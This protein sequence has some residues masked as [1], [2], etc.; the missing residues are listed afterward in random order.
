MTFRAEFLCA[1]FCLVCLCHAQDA[2]KKEKVATPACAQFNV[3]DTTGERGA[4]AKRLWSEVQTE[5]SNTIA[6]VFVQVAQFNWL[7]PYTTPA[8]GEAAGSGFVIDDKGYLITNAHVISEAKAIGIQLPALGKERLDATL[9][10]VSFDRDIAL[11]RITQEGIDKIKAA[12]GCVPHIKLGNSDQVLRGD[13][14]MTLGYPLGQ[15]TLKSTVGV[16]SG[17]ETMEY[18]QYI[19]IDAP[20][21]PGNSGGPSVN[22][23]GEVVGV[24]TAGIPGAQNVGYIIPINELKIVLD[25]LYKL[26][27]VHNKELKKPFLGFGYGASSPAMAALFGNPVGGIYIVEVFKGGLLDK[28][29]VQRGDVLT[30][31]NGYAVDSYGQLNVPWCEDKISIDNYSYY[32]RYGQEVKLVLYRKGEKKNITIIFEHSI[33]PAIRVM[34]PDF[35]QIE[36]EVI[37]GMVI[38]QLTR[39]HLPLLLN[40]SPLL[41]RFSEPKKQLKPMLV[42]THII[43]DSVAQRSRVLAPAA[44]VKEVNGVKVRT[45]EQLREAVLKSAQ[46]GFLTVRVSEGFFAAFPISQIIADEPRLSYIYRYEISETIKKLAQMSS[47]QQI[48]RNPSIR[49]LTDS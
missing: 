21:N 32:L 47:T 6:Q 36:Y 13:E 14:I 26:E 7:E 24:N 8:Q 3:G 11:L 44:L 46:T 37:G 20:I 19:Q 16:V 27:S 5:V 18:R 4:R 48:A 38:M 29:G 30:E 41:I 33:V 31:I 34:H 43:P 17:R 25:D 15:Q 22:F 10:G 40:A 28:A 1:T 12:L 2:I 42:I 49:S 9:V 35:D 45:L 23:N 39:N